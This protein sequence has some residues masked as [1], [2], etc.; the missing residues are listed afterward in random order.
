PRAGKA[1]TARESATGIPPGIG[2]APR[3]RHWQD[4]GSARRTTATPGI[5]LHLLLPP[6]CDAAD[7]NEDD[8][9]QEQECQHIGHV[10]LIVRTLSSARLPFLRIDRDRLDD[11]V[12]PAVDAA[13][14]IVHAEARQD[15]ILDDEARHRIGKCSFETVADLDAY[16]TFVRRND[17]KCPSV[18]FF[19]ANPPVP[20]ELVAI[21]LD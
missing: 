10:G 14:E 5:G 7:D 17:Q 16:L 3:A 4:N 12:H 18:L 20:P 6:P 15:G 21:V 19:L 2:A 11:V 9:H 13:G 8:H 1:A